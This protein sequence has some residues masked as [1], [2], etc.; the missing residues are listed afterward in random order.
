[1]NPPTTIRVAVVLIILSV[2]PSI[3]GFVVYRLVPGVLNPAF[4]FAAVSVLA[5]VAFWSWIAR[6]TWQGRSWARM[7]QTVI[8]PLGIAV[9]T[10]GSVRGDIAFSW[11][12]PIPF[13]LSGAAVVLMWVPTSRS[14]FDAT[15]AELHPPKPMKPYLDPKNR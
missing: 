7:L 12:E 14:Y 9:L 6:K 13:V 2:L 11:T 8:V 5:I 4:G 15:A 3:V 1:M 10:L